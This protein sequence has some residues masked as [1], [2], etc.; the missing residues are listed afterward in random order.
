VE[1]VNNTLQEAN[2][3]I[4]NLTNAFHEYMGNFSSYHGRYQQP[5][6]E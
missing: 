6:N 3:N 5:S 2:T 1:G 4:N